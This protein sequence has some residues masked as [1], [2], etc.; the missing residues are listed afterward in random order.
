[1]NKLKL[2]S[3]SKILPAFVAGDCYLYHRSCHDRNMIVAIK[4]KLYLVRYN[5]AELYKEDQWMF[6]PPI[7]YIDRE[8]KII[9][10]S[11]LNVYIINN[12]SKHVAGYK[13]YL[14]NTIDA[15]NITENIANLTLA[16]I[17]WFV[18][19]IYNV[20]YENEF[21]VIA[22]RQQVYYGSRDKFNDPIDVLNPLNNVNYL[23]AFRKWLEFNKLT[24]SNT[25]NIQPAVYTIIGSRRVDIR[26]VGAIYKYGIFT[27]A[28]EEVLRRRYFYSTQIRGKNNVEHISFAAMNAEWELPFVVDTRF[29]RG[30]KDI[31]KL[32]INIDDWN[33][34][35]PTVSVKANYIRYLLSSVERAEQDCIARIKELCKSNPIEVFRNKD[36]YINNGKFQYIDVYMNNINN[37]IDT[38]IVKCYHTFY[39]ELFD[40]DNVLLCMGNDGNIHTSIGC[41]I[42]YDDAERIY[43]KFINAKAYNEGTTMFTLTDGS[44]YT[45]KV[46]DANTDNAKLTIGCQTIHE[47]VIEDF[48][49]YYK[50]NDW[51]E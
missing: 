5:D 33:S 26:N 13:V 29:T 8:N 37:S 40:K 18:H 22:G 11:T 28:E 2:C 44:T 21:K 24:N 46:K 6:D 7:A 15:V 31:L 34:Q 19:Q 36:E 23:R 12:I 41:V 10:I 35:T 45:F 39:D 47:K 30:A 49:D 43:S 38:C 17:R 25:F 3:K 50:L 9:S 48:I 42:N 27:K 16:T 14:S 1:M 51:R 32:N 20:Q 4:D